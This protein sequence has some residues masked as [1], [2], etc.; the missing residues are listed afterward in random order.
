L[1]ISGQRWLLLVWREGELSRRGDKRRRIETVAF[2]P[3]DPLLG[4][5][6]GIQA[7]SDQDGQCQS[8]K[9]FVLA[10]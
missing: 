1:N 4:P 6:S 9:S 8:A 2:Q 5:T 10:P 3:D 7:R